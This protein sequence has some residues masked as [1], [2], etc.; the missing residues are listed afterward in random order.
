MSSGDSS[1]YDHQPTVGATNFSI[2]STREDDWKFERE[3][4]LSQLTENSLWF[5]ETLDEALTFSE[6]EWKLRARRGT[7][8]TGIRIV[9]VETGTDRWLG[10]M[11][12]Y[13]GTLINGTVSPL[14][15]SV[16]VRDG[17][18]GEDIGITDALLRTVV[19]W[20]RTQADQIGLTVHEDNARAIAAY[21]KRGFV[22]YGVRTTRAGERGVAVELVKSL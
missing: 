4:R 7:E 8:P 12:G 21:A 5:S 2:R 13:V 20:A 3:L 6:E 11:G 17:Y 16:Y 1:S 18:R 14:L 9:A 19:D 15:V 22:D 10:I